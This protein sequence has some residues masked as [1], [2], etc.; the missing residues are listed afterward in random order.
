LRLRAN[1]NHAQRV[2]IAIARA[3]RRAKTMSAADPGFLPVPAARSVRMVK[4]SN[5]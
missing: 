2:G 4:A 1:E 3:P 5:D